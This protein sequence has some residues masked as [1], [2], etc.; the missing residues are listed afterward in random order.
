MPERGAAKHGAPV[1]RWSLALFEGSPKHPGS[2]T[3]S[4]VDVVWERMYEKYFKNEKEFPY[5]EEYLQC[6]S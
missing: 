5:K 3:R 2:K 6:N 4:S 1:R